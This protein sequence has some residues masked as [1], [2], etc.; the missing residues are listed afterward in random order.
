[1][2]MAAADLAATLRD[3][4]PVRL[5]GIVVE[6]DLDLDGLDYPHRLSLTH[7]VF[8]GRVHLNEARFGHTV[9][10]SGCEFQDGLNLFAARIDGQLKLQRARILK[11]PQELV[12]HNFDQ[13]EVRGRLSGK[14]LFSEVPLSFRQA[15]LG[16]VSLDG[17]RVRGDLDLEIAKVA[18]DVFCQALAGERSEVEGCLR[19][20]GLR[21]GGHVDLCGIRIG[22]D[23][24]ASHAE[25][26]GDFLCQP[27]HGFRPEI[28]GAMSLYGAR[29]GGQAGLRGVR[30]SRV[31]EPRIGLNLGS[32]EIREDLR[33]ST[34]DGHRT[35]ILGP[36][37]LAGAK[38][39]GVAHFG[40]ALIGCPP[41]ADGCVHYLALH[42]VEIG[43]GLRICPDGPF[44]PEIRGGVFGPSARIS[45][46]LVLD[47]AR[48]DGDLDFQRA[49][50]NG[51]MLC[52][53]DEE[54][55]AAR[56]DASGKEVP[57]HL[58]VAGRLDLTGAHVQELV[59]DGRL[60]D[61]ADRPEPPVDRQSR[62]SER[63]REFYRRLITGRQAPEPEARLQ[64]DRAR[65]SKLAIRNRIPDLLSA[66]G[67]TFDDLE[68]PGC[69]GENE[70]TELL[71]R[72]HPFKRSTYLAVES[73]LNNKGLDASARRVYREM[74][75]RDLVTGRSTFLGRWLRYLFLGVAIGY[76]A[77]PQRLIGL[78][79]LAFALSCWLFAQPGSLVSY[80][81]KP[82]AKPDPLPAG[83]ENAWV[84]LGVALRCHF[85]MLLFLGEPNYV[86]SP[87][88]IPGLELRYDAY[89]LMISAV[90]WVL[91]PLFLAGLTGIVRKRE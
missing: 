29:V 27:A 53:F 30:V 91:V 50:V 69:G 36:V 76:G 55:Y 89:A 79:L 77:R 72:T 38:I 25:I 54:F 20:S 31:E 39:G 28:L 7:C 87:N 1:M 41:S 17:L 4:I 49:T 83:A 6:G 84:T 35:E 45:H 12:R 51:R 52:A 16:E 18:G 21:V 43:R 70:Y 24:D 56:P 32:A 44:R 37:S 23:L 74:S 47:R 85:P 26:H 34:A 46:M 14:H 40:G 73:W 63:R 90:S 68:L 5:D 3:R 82:A 22:G 64:L 71:R 11:G 42:G 10:L 67:L 58:E 78:F 81:E 48:I 60:F 75:D 33:C 9:D 80:S 86:P 2:P 19:L 65:L 57:G 13:I 15:R 62:R 59:L 61:A 66:D 8:R 88:R